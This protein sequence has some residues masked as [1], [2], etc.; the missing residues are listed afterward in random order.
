LVNFGLADADSAG[1]PAFLVTSNSRN[2]PL[3]ERLGF[4]VTEEYD[5]GPVHV[6]AMLHQPKSG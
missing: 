5:I 2:V 4:V 3:Y 1:V 6:W